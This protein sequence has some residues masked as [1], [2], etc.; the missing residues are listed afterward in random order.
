MI[1]IASYDTIKIYEATL[2]LNCTDLATLTPIILNLIS[3]N[4]HIL[5][6]LDSVLVSAPEPKLRRKNRIRTIKATLAIEGNTFTIDQITAILE[7]KKENTR[8]TLF[9]NEKKRLKTL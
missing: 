9:V 8:Q 3:E 2:Y 7:N 6:R 4:S 5:G 1:T